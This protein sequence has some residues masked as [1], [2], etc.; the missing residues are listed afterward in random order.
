VARR[1]TG[2]TAAQNPGTSR[3]FGGARRP[4]SDQRGLLD[5]VWPETVV[6][7]GVLKTSMGELRKALG[8]T[9]KAPQ[10]IATVYGWGY[11]F[12]APVHVVDRGTPPVVPSVLSAPPLLLAPASPPLLL[13][14]EGVLQ[15]LHAGWEQALQGRRQV[16]FVTGEAGIGKTAVVEAFAIQVRRE[17][18]V[19]VAYGQCVEHYGAGEAYLPVLE[20][21]EQLCRGQVGEDL[22]GLLRQH[23]PTWLVQLP[24]LLTPTDRAQLQYELQGA[25]RER[26]LREFAAVVET[27]TVATPLLLILEDLHWSDAATLDVLALLARRRTPARLFIVGTYRP[28]AALGPPHPLPTVVQDMQ[29]YGVA[30]ELPLAGL[31]VEAVATY[32]A[33]RFPQQQFPATLAPWLHQRTDGQPLFLV[34]LGACP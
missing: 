19:A 28:V 1:A 9:A 17:P 3:L 16:I 5:A 20:V 31:S 30:T 10:W 25:T 8:E 23:A 12:I 24:W 11:R 33:A 21:V 4:G 34:T 6:G 29:R 26:M 18:T 13:E 22:V 32:L 14:R 27:L 2:T 15:R 7:D